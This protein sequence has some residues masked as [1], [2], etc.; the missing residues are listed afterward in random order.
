MKILFVTASYLPVINGVSYQI[1]ILKNAL[2]KMGHQVYV[3][4]PSFPGFIDTDSNIIRYPSFPNPIVKAYPIGIPLF[5]FAKIAKI[6][7]DIIHVHHPFI[8]GQLGKQISEKLKVPLFFTAHTNYVEYANYYFPFVSTLT[9]KFIDSDI[10]DLSNYCFKIICPTLETQKRI[11]T[12]GIK[13]TIV[14]HNSIN[15]EFFTNT[16]KKGLNNPTI[17]FTGRLEKEKNPFLLIKIAKQLDSRGFNYKMLI[18]G[19][20]SLKYKLEESVV[21]LNLQKKVFVTGEIKR[22]LLP[23]IYKNAHL[24]ITPSLTEVLPLT[25]IEAMACSLPIIALEKS[26]LEEIV[27]NNKTGYLLKANQNIAKKIQDIF[28][29]KKLYLTLSTGAYLH[30]KNFSI[31]QKAKDHYQIYKQSLN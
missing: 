11:N 25:L 13:N 16:Q 12:L 17:I 30:S 14:I 24:F 27:I 22:E 6:K 1:D 18:I 19:D 5:S 23:Q 7:P 15:D 21:E 31:S 3:L 26:K 8:Y 9:K 4:T 10:K 28:A 20:G 29:N 2:S